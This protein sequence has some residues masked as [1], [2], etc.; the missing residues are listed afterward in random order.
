M[1]QSGRIPYKSNIPC[2][3]LWCGDECTHI[4][5]TSPDLKW[6][7]GTSAAFLL[8]SVLARVIVKKCLKMAHLSYCFQLN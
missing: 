2:G 3:I 8:I 1:E 6:Q 5:K 4:S 7:C